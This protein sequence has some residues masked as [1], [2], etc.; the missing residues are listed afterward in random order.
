[1][2]GVLKKGN[3]GGMNKLG[4]DCCRKRDVFST[5]LQVTR[6]VLGYCGTSTVV[7]DYST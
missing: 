7:L 4:D 2:C 1:M 3:N 6:P 5:R